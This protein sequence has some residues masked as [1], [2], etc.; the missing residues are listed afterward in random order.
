MDDF[1][2]IF[3]FTEEQRELALRR[4]R[5]SIESILG[6]KVTPCIS[7]NSAYC[8]KDFLTEVIGRPYKYRWKPYTENYSRAHAINWGVKQL[9]ET[10]H[11]Y[12]SD[13]DLVYQPHHIDVIEKMDGRVVFLNENSNVE[14][15]SSNWKDYEGLPSD[16]I[17]FAHGNGKICT[18]IFYKIRGYDEDLIGYGPEDDLFNKRYRELAPVEYSRDSR[19]STK[20]IWHEPFQRLQVAKNHEIYDER[21]KNIKHYIVAN[22]NKESWG[23]I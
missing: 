19:L 10:P 3:N 2:W 8:I 6:Q 17:N 23:E 21:L 16:P 15:Y 1:L 9:V 11:F 22:N 4:F 5:C 7:N 14:F 12:I 13:V 20:H 18:D